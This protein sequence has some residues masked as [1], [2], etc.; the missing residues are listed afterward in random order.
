M[1][2]AM[3]IDEACKTLRQANDAFVLRNALQSTQGIAEAVYVLK[4]YLEN[5]RADGKPLDELLIPESALLTPAGLRW[6]MTYVT[7]AESLEA[8]RR[9]ARSA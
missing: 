8:S 9:R 2:A 7:S 5:A 3:N 4:S 1:G 6:V